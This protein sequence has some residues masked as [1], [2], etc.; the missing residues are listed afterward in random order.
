MTENGAEKKK[1]KKCRRQEDARKRK[2]EMKEKLT[3]E[4]EGRRLSMALGSLKGLGI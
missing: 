2:E 3:E 4:T 1:E